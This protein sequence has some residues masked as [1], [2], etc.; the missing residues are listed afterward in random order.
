MLS[1]P[2]YVRMAGTIH[3]VTWYLKKLSNDPLKAQIYIEKHL[4]QPISGENRTITL[5][6]Q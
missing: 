3:M 2:I 6:L 4:K 5:L 1:E